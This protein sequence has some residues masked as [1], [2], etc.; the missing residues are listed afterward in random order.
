MNIIDRKEVFVT[1]LPRHIAIIMDGNGRWAKQQNLPRIVGH[2]AGAKS[3]RKVIKACAEKHINVLSLFAFGVDNWRRPQDEVDSLMKL[4]YMTLQ[5]EAKRLHKNNI[6]LIIIGDLN[7]FNQK[8]QNKINETMVLTAQNTGMVLVIAANYSGQW[9]FQQAAVNLA[10][11]VKIGELAIEDLTM[12]TV[13]N[14]MC[15]SDL[16]SPDLFIRTSGEQRISNFFLWQ[17]A[18]TELYKHC[19]LILMNTHLMKR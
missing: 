6:K 12:D 9:D 18:Y 16:P 13:N 1:N 17:L 14:S 11:K 4:F 3:A 10:N 15:L 2:E 5:R 8:L 19:G 7:H